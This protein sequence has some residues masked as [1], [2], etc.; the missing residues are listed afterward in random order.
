MND[1]LISNPE[2]L[3]R[4]VDAFRASGARGFRVLSDWDR[5][6]AK[7]ATEGN[8]DQSTYSL[9]FS[10]NYL[11]EEY[12][13]RTM[14]LYD[15]YRRVETAHDIPESEKRTKMRDWW[16]KQFELMVEFGFSRE[17]IR[18]IVRKSELCVREGAEDFF[19]ILHRHG[20]PLLILSA[21]IGN[22][23]DAY[24]TE[25]GFLTPNVHIIANTFTFG[26]NGKAD[27]YEAP[28]IHIMNKNEKQAA[29]SDRCDAARSGENVLLLGDALEDL[30]MAD[31]IA[32]DRM[33]SC[34]FLNDP[35]EARL[36][37][38]MQAYDVVIPNDGTL[39]FVNRLL[40]KFCA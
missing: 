12:N 20:V 30:R 10:G 1:V 2:T 18:R 16:E 23:I 5:T 14:A 13:R 11:G 39:D 4:K 25:Q 35:G 36:R 33:I 3:R 32:P 15:I 8:A 40:R 38:Y 22:M 29:A 19:R 26:D 21:G 34:G 37:R 7:A 6:L 27:G 17:I 24:L 28:L 31:G 9:I